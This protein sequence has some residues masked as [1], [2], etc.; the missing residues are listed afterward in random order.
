MAERLKTVDFTCKFDP[1]NGRPLCG[2]VATWRCSCGELRCDEHAGET[3][4]CD[5]CIDNPDDC[6]KCGDQRKACKCPEGPTPATPP[7]LDLDDLDA[8][9]ARVAHLPFEVYGDNEMSWGFYTPLPGTDGQR[10][11]W[12]RWHHI[13]AADR[14]IVAPQTFDEVIQ[15]ECDVVDFIAVASRRLPVAVAEIRALRARVD[16]AE[17]QRAAAQAKVDSL[18]A[19]FGGD[20]S[21][22][23]FHLAETA[24][25][26]RGE[27]QEKTS[28]ANEA[29][30]ERD[31]A[32][33]S[34]D[35]ALAALERERGRTLETGELDVNAELTRRVAELD[36]QL[37]EYRKIDTILDEVQDGVRHVKARAHFVH[38]FAG[39]MVGWF[40]DQGALN[41]VEQSFRHDE[42][43]AFTLHLQRKAG[44][45]PSELRE[46][47]EER[48]RQ[49]RDALN[50]SLNENAD[51]KRRI[52]LLEADEG[53]P[54]SPEVTP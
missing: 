41:Y 19:R 52:A 2:A 28:D 35:E 13:G 26:W 44:K 40:K 15:Y 10:G 1:R 21:E 51:L 9:C 50:D 7:P 8:V 16:E 6:H 46:E 54:G 34:R 38:Q 17:L 11:E 47:A 33:R 27:A 32:L 42:L 5:R 14:S 48:A 23:P 20:E 49:A 22:D 37:A 31:E 3:G 45:T 25:F 4:L 36:E 43:G 18:Y 29:I 39:L 12:D 53:P 24:Q 30:A